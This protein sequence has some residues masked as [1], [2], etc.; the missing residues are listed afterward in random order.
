MIAHHRRVDQAARGGV[1]A[2][3]DIIVFFTGDEETERQGR[4]DGRDRV[5]K[6]CSTPNMRSTPTPAAGHSRRRAPARLRAADRRENLSRAINSP[7]RNRGGHTSRP[8]PDNAIYE[9]SAALKR[10]AHAS[11]QPVLNETT[12]AY[13][14][15]RGQAGERRAWRMRCAR[16]SPIPNDGEAADAIEANE[17]ETGI[18]RTRCVATMLEGGH[19]QNALAAD[20]RGQRSIAGSCPGSSPKTIEAELEAV[21]GAGV[22]VTPSRTRA[23]LPSRLAAAGRRGRGLHRA[24]R[25]THGNDASRSSRK[26]RP[27]R[28]TA[29]FSAQAGIPVYGIEAPWGISPDDER[30]HG[31]DERI[32][33]RRSTTTCFTG[34]I[35]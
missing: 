29:C 30:A 19:A 26:C 18:T 33:A 14:T 13:F 2:N 20:A 11:F 31:L 22:E 35:S 25:M 6:H 8:R 15:A 5:A 9:L 28:P 16:G 3:R 24:V 17:L 12:R 23:G 34:N 21:A 32:P 10:L 27:A 7:R 4:A 1:Q